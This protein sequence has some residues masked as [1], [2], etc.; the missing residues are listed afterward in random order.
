MVD[1]A[2]LEGIDVALVLVG[3]V[4]AFVGA[5]V[6][7][8]AVTLTGFLVGGGVGYILAPSLAGVLTLEGGLLSAGAVA[9]GG[10]VGAF[11]AYAGLSMAVLGIGAIVGAFLGR[12]AVGPFY[13]E[14]LLPLV[15]AT[16]A[17]VAVGALLGF[18]LT[19]TTLVFSTGFIGAA[20][21]SRSLT[22]ADFGAAT[23]PIA[24]DPLLFDPTAPAFLA[25]LILGILTQL[26]LFRFG[27][28]TSIIG[29]LPG[30]RRW[31]ASDDGDGEH[32]G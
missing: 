16:L 13:V 29:V 19:R 4:L 32:G 17:G 30:A 12:F 26:G 31:T 21:A 2:A 24:L 1:I 18:V 27:Y 3:L 5:A 8:Y 22:I 9:I 10:A 25:V 28:V 11:L 23:D 14:G 20:F 15:G 6:S 7:V